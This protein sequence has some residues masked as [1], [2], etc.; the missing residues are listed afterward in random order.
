MP[1]NFCSFL[2][3]EIPIS[4]WPSA[5]QN[6]TN[7]CT[8]T[9]GSNQELLLCPGQEKALC[10]PP[11]IPVEARQGKGLNHQTSTIGDCALPITVPTWIFGQNQGL[12][13][14]H[15]ICKAR[16]LAPGRTVCQVKLFCPVLESQL[17]WELN[18]KRAEL[19]TE[20]LAMA[21]KNGKKVNSKRGSS[22]PLLCFSL[23]LMPS[24]VCFRSQ[25][26]LSTFKNQID[27][28]KQLVNWAASHL[29]SRKGHH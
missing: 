19:R 28:L 3:S 4:N 7:R 27:F 10:A 23:S 25:I 6:K 29:A 24:E 26:Q 18:A 2:T 9:Y 22:I 15:L 20:N 13:I 16:G 14:F 12:E 1:T 17:H 11:V 8:L 21:L 5:T